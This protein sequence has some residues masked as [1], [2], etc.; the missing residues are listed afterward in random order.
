M[1][2]F[3]VIGRNFV[4]EDFLRAAAQVPDV[5]AAGVYS[6]RADTAQA[7]AA[8]HGIL[9][10]YTQIEALAADSDLDFIYIAS[11][12]LCHEAQTVALLRAG[13]HILVEKPAAPSL[14]AFRRMQHAAP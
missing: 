11:P 14:D 12:N 3:A 9:R 13:K 10:T 5:Q 8:Q 2:R 4:V 1:Y 7:F 6:R